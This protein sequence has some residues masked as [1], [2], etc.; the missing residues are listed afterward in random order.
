MRKELA[1][2]LNNVKYTGPKCASTLLPF[3]QKAEFE[4][5]NYKLR[6]R[7]TEYIVK[8]HDADGEEVKYKI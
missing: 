7:F 1:N 4:L 2:Y 5:L 8:L 3:A 6:G